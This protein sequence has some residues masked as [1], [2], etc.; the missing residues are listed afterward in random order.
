MV[1]DSLA[2]L[3]N[4]GDRHTVL[5]KADAAIACPSKIRTLELGNEH[6]G[7]GFLQGDRA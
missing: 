7:T 4:V 1:C 5:Y 3:L 2:G 6:S